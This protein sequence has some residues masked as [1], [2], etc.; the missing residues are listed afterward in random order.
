MYGDG[1]D[2]SNDGPEKKVCPQCGA[3]LPE[4]E[5]FCMAC[6]MTVIPVL[7]KDYDKAVNAGQDPVAYSKAFSTEG[8]ESSGAVRDYTGGGSSG[9]GSSYDGG[10]THGGGSYGGG[11]SYNGGGSYGGGN[12]YGGQSRSS[13][14]Y[15]K[16][17]N[18]P[19]VLYLTFWALVALAAIAVLVFFV[20]KLNVEKNA[21]KTTTL[22][23]TVKDDFSVEEDTVIFTSNGDKVTKIT[24]Q[25]E[26]SIDGWEQYYVDQVKNKLDQEYAAYETSVSMHYKIE[27]IED[28]KLI[29]TIEYEYLNLPENI[30]KMIDDGLLEKSGMD[31]SEISYK[32][33]ISLEKSTS[34]LRKEGYKVRRAIED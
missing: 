27:Q 32:D 4:N 23:R 11:S 30:Q 20:H 6:G 18:E 14:S 24:Y 33:Y 8:A 28:K 22:Y 3:E 1:A 9:G 21:E 31:N 13:S 12:S 25:T 34:N 15:S 2:D 19:S 10:N 29:V 26:F 7:K 5:T 17:E 16:K